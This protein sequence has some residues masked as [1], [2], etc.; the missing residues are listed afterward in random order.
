MKNK[1]TYMLTQ[2]GRNQGEVLVALYKANRF[3][4]VEELVSLS[5]QNKD[6]VIAFLDTWE[7][8][9]SIERMADDSKWGIVPEVREV[10]QAIML[11][12]G[13]SL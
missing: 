9:G 5:H 4:A 2:K 3:L 6:T 13:W 1:D 12:N 8:E 10:I 7:K 11:K